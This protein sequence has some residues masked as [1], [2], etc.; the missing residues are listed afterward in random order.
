MLTLWVLPHVQRHLLFLCRFLRSR[1]QYITF[2]GDH[3]TPHPLASLESTIF[4]QSRYPYRDNT[5][6]AF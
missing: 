1:L 4:A 5:K 2:S 3:L 6:T